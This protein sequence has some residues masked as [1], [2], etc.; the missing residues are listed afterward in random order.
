MPAR[1]GHA[2]PPARGRLPGDRSRARAFEEPVPPR[3][4]HGPAQRDVRA[5]RAADRRRAPPW[6]SPTATARTT[7][8]S[9]SRRPSRF[10]LG[11][12]ARGRSKSV[13]F[14]RPGRGARLLRHPLPHERVHP[15]LRPPLLR[16]HRRRGPLPHRRRARRAPTRVVA[17]NDGQARA[18][19]RTVRV[20][21]TG[22]VVELDFVVRMTRLLPPSRPRSSWPARSWPCSRIAFAVRFVTDRVARRGRGRAARAAC[23]R[24]APWSSSTTR[25]RARRSPDGRA[26]GGGPA[27]AQGGGG[28][29]RPAHGGAAG[30]R[31]PA[32][33]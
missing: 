12:Y 13:R 23:W 11:R 21:E 15:R 8:S 5:L 29:E 6:T 14:D 22:G 33:A 28:H 2:R 16:R 26:P 10:D 17:W 25:A 20:P 30:R 7:T 4:R 9:R 18:E 27:Q 1:A 32:R 31:L 19:P 24:R 3:A